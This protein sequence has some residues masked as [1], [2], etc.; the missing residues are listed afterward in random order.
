MLT[1]AIR[2]AG[3]TVAVLA[4]AFVPAAVV[5]APRPARAAAPQTS[6]QQ[7]SAGDATSRFFSTYRL[8]QGNVDKTIAA[9]QM[10]IK[11]AK[12]NPTFLK[13]LSA[14]GEGDKTIDEVA[15]RIET[16]PVTSAAL[17]AAGIN[18]HDFIGTIMAFTIAAGYVELG[19]I[20]AQAAQQAIQQL[21]PVAAENVAYIGVHP[22]QVK[23]MEE[24]Q[25][26]MKQV[27]N[28]A[29]DKQQ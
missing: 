15:N 9:G 5:A 6:A 1:R 20:N 12:N 13:Q 28:G 17:K 7:H 11:A 27:E 16:N 18:G 22:D 21:G 26:Q 3:I 4:T 23:A 19:K 8:T 25:K 29:S 14:A 2:R 10:V 24:L